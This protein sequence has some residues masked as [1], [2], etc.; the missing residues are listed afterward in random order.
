MGPHACESREHI[1]ESCDFYLGFGVGGLCTLG[2]YLEDQAGS[3][4][5]LGGFYYLFDITLLHSGKFVVEDAVAYV[6]F[7]T[8][9]LY[10]SKFTASDIGCFFGFVHSLDKFPVSFCACCFRQE[11]QFIKIFHYLGFVIVLTYD[12]YEYSLFFGVLSGFEHS[13]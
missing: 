4:D 11:F 13:I 3:V 6:I 9:L 8:I 2:K 10:F 7:F 5:Y 1:V 12:S